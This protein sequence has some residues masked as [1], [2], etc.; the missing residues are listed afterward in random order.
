[1]FCLTEKLYANCH[2]PLID[3]FRDSNPCFQHTGERLVHVGSV[4]ATAI[5]SIFDGILGIKDGIT[6]IL[7]GGSDLES[8]KSASLRL[9][10]LEHCLSHVFKHSL[11]VVNIHSKF[12]ENGEYGI[13]T[14][15]LVYGILKHS[16][17]ESNDHHN[18]IAAKLTLIVMATTAVLTRIVDLAIGI[19]ATLAAFCTLGTQK[20]INDMAFRGL[21]ITGIFYDVFY[22][23]AKLVNLEA[24]CPPYNFEK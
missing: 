21:K 9:N 24:G 18:V 17:R 7:T 23:S 3:F 15:H 2:H 12:S 22:C 16:I 11:S 1:M 10:S 6:C 20:S 14:N 8:W 4:P 13:L 19:F 5:A